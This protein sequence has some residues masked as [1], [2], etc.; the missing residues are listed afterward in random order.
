M[1]RLILL[2]SGVIAL[3]LGAVFLLIG[4]F[5]GQAIND[6]EWRNI[7]RTGLPSHAERLQWSAWQANDGTVYPFSNFQPEHRPEV[8]SEFRIG[9]G[10]G[11]LFDFI[12]YQG[13]FVRN[14]SRNVFPAIGPSW[15]A[16]SH[17]VW[18]CVALTL[19]TSIV[20]LSAAR[21]SASRSREKKSRLRASF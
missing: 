20:C 11:S 19:A 2:G 9:R 3:A 13:R 4:L 12:F 18:A 8:L 6:A 14:G 17:R 5:V 15:G 10:R 7:T 21:R 1:L 16:E